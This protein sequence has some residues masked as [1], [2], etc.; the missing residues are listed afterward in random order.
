MSN[1]KYIYKVIYI[2]QSGSRVMFGR[3]KTWLL[4]VVFTIVAIS[5]GT[6]CER[7]NIVYTAGMLLVC[8][9]L[10]F[11]KYGRIIHCLY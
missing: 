2:K 5:L 6:S 7:L 10:K 3:D 8:T 11:N 1:I 9:K 4:I